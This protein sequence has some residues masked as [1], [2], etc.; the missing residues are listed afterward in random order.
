MIGKIYF[1]F[2]VVIYF[3]NFGAI[4]LLLY[5]VSSDLT[6]FSIF[7][8]ITINWNLSTISSIL[9]TNDTFC[10]NQTEILFSYTF[11]GILEGCQCEKKLLPGECTDEEI[12]KECR[13]IK[14]IYKS[15]FSQI[16]NMTYCALRDK[17]LL[18]INLYKNRLY[19]SKENCK[20]KK[21]C[22]VADSIGNVL[23]VNINEN[24][25]Y[26]YVKDN[27]ELERVLNKGNIF[28]V[29]FKLSH[30]KVCLNN[31]QYV[32]GITPAY[33]LL[34]NAKQSNCSSLKF[35][36]VSTDNRYHYIFSS[37]TN[38]VISYHYSQRL[39]SLPFF[40]QSFLNSKINVYGRMFIGWKLKCSS[41]FDSLSRID[42]LS[43]RISIYSPLYLI[44]SMFLLLYNLLFLMIMK[45]TFIENPIS[46][47]LLMIL[48]S[49][50]FIVIIIMLF[51]DDLHIDNVLAIIEKSIDMNCS[52]YHTMIVFVNLF[53]MTQ[54]LQK[55]YR[56]ITILFLLMEFVSLIKF[57]VLYYKLNKYYY[58]SRIAQ[59]TPIEV[60]N[61]I[62]ELVN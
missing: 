28:Y 1:S 9:I 18:Y 35:S 62:K 17:Q 60:P 2:N 46:E 25:P 34:N 41:F 59:N 45:E 16:N 48:H 49:L 19:E 5:I 54:Y 14:G 10:P 23:C 32:F 11:P 21:F 40:P 44:F 27:K 58:V 56:E 13:N 52:D 47:L 61:V 38:E 26:I 6:I 37:Y 31:E 7:H 12:K 55:K 30:D 53:H 24:C 29:E 22:G 33:P 8:Q 51:I 42:S 3:L 57:G 20:D 4:I 15:S 43:Y 50:S 36:D 39:Q